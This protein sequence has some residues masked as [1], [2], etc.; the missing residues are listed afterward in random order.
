MDSLQDCLIQATLQLWPATSLLNYRPTS[1]GQ[2][3]MSRYLYGNYVPNLAKRFEKEMSVIE[4]KHNFELGYEFEIAICKMLRRTLPQK[5][6]ICRGYV[7]AADGRSAGDDIV[8]FDQGRFPTLRSL[9]DENYSQKENVPVEAAYAYIEAKHTLDV[10]GNGPSSLAQACKQV[11]DVKVLCD[12][13]AKVPL[14]GVRRYLTLDKTFHAIAPPGHPDQLN[15]MYGAVFARRVRRKVKQKV[16]SDPQQVGALLH[17]FSMQA[18][19]KADAII[20][21][22]GV[23]MLP[24]IPGPKPGHFGFASPFV[25]NGVSTARVLVCPAMAFGIGLCLTLFA[26]DWIQLGQ[27]PWGEIIINA[28]DPPAS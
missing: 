1:E 17:G 14:S 12:Q 16:I 3:F 28:A 20:F 24:V 27:M 19:R 2:R 18:E 4:A 26:L 21:G 22:S 11:S 10:E 25:L 13:R 9:G 15:P 23:V 7:V 6:G 5:F 8:I